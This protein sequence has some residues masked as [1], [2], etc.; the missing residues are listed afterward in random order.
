M[1]KES[2]KP[3]SLMSNVTTPKSGRSKFHLIHKSNKIAPV[4]STDDQTEVS[5]LGQL[6]SELD[7]CV[8]SVFGG[9]DPRL[10]RLPISREE[11]S[12]KVKENLTMP[13]LDTYSILMG[14]SPDLQYY[15]SINMVETVIISTKTGEV[16]MRASELENERHLLFAPV[17]NVMVLL[18]AEQIKL[19]S[20]S[21]FKEQAVIQYPNG[22]CPKILGSRVVLLNNRDV[23]DGGASY[24]SEC[25]M[26]CD[27]EAAY[28]LYIEEGQTTFSKVVK[29]PFPEEVT[30]LMNKKPGILI[31]DH[32]SI[33]IVSNLNDS[34]IFNKGSKV[35]TVSR[36]IFKSFQQCLEAG[37]MLV[38]SIIQV[39]NDDP[40]NVVNTLEF[41]SLTAQ[42]DL[43]YFSY[44]TK[45]IYRYVETLNYFKEVAS[46]YQEI[47]LPDSLCIESKGQKG[48]FV[49]IDSFKNS[50]YV[51]VIIIS[52]LRMTTEVI[53][54]GRTDRTNS[55]YK[56]YL[57]LKKGTKCMVK[58]AEDKS[59]F[60]VFDGLSFEKYD[61]N[62]PNYETVPEF[63]THYS[64]IPGSWHSKFYL[65]NDLGLSLVGNSWSIKKEGFKQIDLEKKSKKRWVSKRSNHLYFSTE[66]GLNCI[67]CNSGHSAVVI[68]GT[69]ATS[70]TVDPISLVACKTEDEASYFYEMEG[71]SLVSGK[72]NLLKVPYEVSSFKSTEDFL[73]I[74]QT[75]EP[76]SVQ[77]YKSTLHVHLKKNKLFA[78]S[79]KY[80]VGFHSTQYQ[81]LKLSSKNKYVFSCCNL[82][83][84]VVRIEDC[85][86]VITRKLDSSRG[87]YMQQDCEVSICERF[88][89][90][91]HFEAIQ[92]FHIEEN[93]L[94]W[95]FDINRLENLNFE[96]KVHCQTFMFS[97]Y[98]NW[99]F[100]NES[101]IAQI[102]VF[103]IE[104]RQIIGRMEW[105][106]N[107]IYIGME[108]SIDGKQLI[109]IFREVLENTGQSILGRKLISLDTSKDDLRIA[110]IED[111]IGKHLETIVQNKKSEYLSKNLLAIIESHG[112]MCWALNPFFSL[113]LIFLEDLE[114]LES[115]FSYLSIERML[116]NHK[117]MTLL[118][119]TSKTNSLKKILSQLEEFSTKNNRQP[120]INYEEITDLML[121]Q[122]ESFLKN[123]T[124]KSFLRSLIL[125]PTSVRIVS[126]FSQDNRVFDLEPF[127][128]VKRDLPSYFERLTKDSAEKDMHEVETYRCYHSLFPLD[129]RN[130][131][132]FSRVLF[133]T[134]QG[135]SDED[136]KTKYYPLVRYKWKMIKWFAYLYAFLILSCTVLAYIYLGS[137]WDLQVLGGLTILLNSFFILYEVKCG[138]SQGK[139]Y[140]QEIFNLFDLIVHGFSIGTVSAMI[141][142][143]GQDP[144]LALN[145]CRVITI[146]FLG[147]RTITWLRINSQTRHLISILLAVFFDMLPFIVI[148]TG[149]IFI[150]GFAWKLTPV[151]LEDPYS[152]GE[153]SF[154]EAIQVPVY[155]V[156]GNWPNT[157]ADGSIFNTVKFLIMVAG[158]LVITLTLAN[159]LIALLSGTFERISTEAEVHNVREMLAL[160]TEFDV[161]LHNPCS[162]NIIEGSHWLTMLPESSEGEEIN[163]RLASIEAK[164]DS[165]FDE[166]LEAIRSLNNK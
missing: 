1:D 79:K 41:N 140:F 65:K 7:S 10:P 20:L 88:L 131:S 46:F 52:Y 144:Y 75:E 13:E 69:D 142:L 8:V 87:D 58:I 154:Y 133:T 61:L 19:V 161:F 43:V 9:E 64:H 17:T 166:I 33:F 159:F 70:F 162:K 50:K 40:M 157:E 117:I 24:F 68:A 99:I 92:I 35:M 27:N 22:N 139:E 55:N 119:K 107:R 141:R 125:G 100:I 95:N 85:I 39:K 103:D 123:E 4:D 108:E 49:L 6:L 120:L 130:G 71:Q 72:E 83:L 80:E 98:R 56:E 5:A 26:C 128:S 29:I 28:Y 78:L 67:D 31:Q 110:D 57:T 16:V 74:L 2:A 15:F 114:L 134:I 163:A 53:L 63:F 143:N 127:T 45:N 66:S 121:N 59:C 25:V 102:L 90:T 155:M 138:I 156:F 96:E 148:L 14:F 76:R 145:W 73:I 149:F 147:Y 47:Q 62:L 86:P 12:V 93:V 21:S 32:Q 115:Y 112:W 94:L 111:T 23:S 3:E 11:R 38:S 81:D 150:F 89:I 106:T 137:R 126:Q 34:S 42:Q 153:L 129:M 82:Q 132:N 51:L 54:Y 146:V 44:S 48:D 160:I 122:N 118:L 60:M 135:V 105:E 158:N 151:L 113:L 84:F 104:T 124:G 164:L 109:L 116:Q 101:S 97:S 77:N 36:V 91:R 152:R 30:Q 18:A 37:Q 165:R 136:L